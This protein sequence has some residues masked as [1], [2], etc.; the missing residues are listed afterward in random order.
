MKIKSLEVLKGG[1]S[2]YFIVGSMDE[3]LRECTAI[4]ENTIEAEGSYY[5]SRYEVYYNGQIRYVI[6]NLG[7]IVEYFIQRSDR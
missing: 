1:C 7:V 2:R 6:E 5:V 3:D 4:R